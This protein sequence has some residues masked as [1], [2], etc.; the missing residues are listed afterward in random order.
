MIIILTPSNICPMD[1]RDKI[2][3]TEMRDGWKAKPAAENSDS[4]KRLPTPAKCSRKGLV[5]VTR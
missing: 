5:P 4:K 1:Y 3:G 2:N